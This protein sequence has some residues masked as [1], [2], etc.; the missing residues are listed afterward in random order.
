MTENHSMKMFWFESLRRRNSDQGS[1]APLGLGFAAISLTLV[2]VLLAASSLFIF[3][4]RLKNFSEGVAVYV[5]QSGES[6]QSYLQRVGTHRF[7][8]VQVVSSLNSDGVTVQA[9]TCAQWDFPVPLLITKGSGQI[10][11]QAAARLE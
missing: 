4:K 9:K 11:A 5:A 7:K 1:I 10:C 8:N 3:Q 6:A 2:F